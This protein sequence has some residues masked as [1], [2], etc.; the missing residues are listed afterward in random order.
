M[1]SVFQCLSNIFPLT[2][3]LLTNEYLNEINSYNSLGS[4]GNII[5]AYVELL[6]IIWKTKIPKATLDGKPCY[7]YDQMD[8]SNSNIMDAFTNLKDEIGKNNIIYNDYQQHDAIEFFIYF[9]DIIHEDLKRI[10]DDSIRVIDNL[11]EKNVEILFNNKWDI[12]KN[13]NNS[14]ITDIF[15]GMN[16]TSILCS[17]C[18]KTYH[19]FEPYNIIFL[20]LNE[21]LNKAKKE[22]VESSKKK[23][24]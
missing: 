10:N 16:H 11:K 4:K 23:T 7:Y 19:I 3:Y 22:E 18:L 1:N 20:P 2:K 5:N 15:Y 13:N 8:K 14:I 17:N 24:I 9:L 21:S 6:K 12:F